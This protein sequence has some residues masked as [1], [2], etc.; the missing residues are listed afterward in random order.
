LV[1]LASKNIVGSYHSPDWALCQSVRA[2]S[3]LKATF[4]TVRRDHHAWLVSGDFQTGQF[5]FQESFKP[6]TPIIDFGDA[7]TF[8]QSY[9]HLARHKGNDGYFYGV[10]DTIEDHL[11]SRDVGFVI[12]IQP[13]QRSS[14]FLNTNTRIMI[15]HSNPTSLSAERVKP[16]WAVSPYPVYTRAD[17]S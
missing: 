14:K 11:M 4:L 3:E 16:S 15:T 8:W 6:L 5:S 10:T 12:S 1:D 7:S 17:Y 13:E 2:E 9:G